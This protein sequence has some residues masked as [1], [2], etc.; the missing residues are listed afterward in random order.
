MERRSSSWPYQAVLLPVSSISV[1]RP[2]SMV[3]SYLHLEY[4]I[5]LALVRT[6][7][8]KPQGKPYQAAP[9]S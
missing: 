8:N 6:Q 1:F 4:S 5:R 3:N 9:K 7:P 2:I